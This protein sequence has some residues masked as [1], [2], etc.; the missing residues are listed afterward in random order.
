MPSSPS[1]T[2]SLGSVLVIGGC[3]FLGH[4]IVR[5]LLT[6]YSCTVSVIDLSVTR[7]RHANASYHSGDITSLETMT[8]LFSLIRP[9]VIIHT[10]SPTVTNHSSP[11]LYE[12]VNV[13][14]TRTLL[15]AAA[16]LPPGTV[17]AFIY[18]S[19]ASVV[20]D[21]ISPLCNATEDFPVLRAPAQ[22]DA[23]NETKGIAEGLVLAANRTHGM[24]T[25]A[26]RPSGIF[27]EG[28]VQ[29]VPGIYGAYTRGQTGFQ[30]GDNTNLS[31]FTYVG[32][33]V[34]AHILAVI[35]LLNTHALSPTIPL[36]HERV[37]GE[38]FFITNGSPT[39]FWD[40]ARAI[41]A[42][43]GDKREPQTGVWVIPKGPG[44]VIASIIEW[45]FWIVFLGK[46]T[47][48]LT[49]RVVN[50]SAMTR[51]YSIDKARKRLGYEPVVGLEQGLKRSVK[52]LIE[53]G[54]EGPQEGGNGV[55]EK[56]EKVQ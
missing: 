2:K 23:Y 7:N 33:V 27:G 34:H 53:N 14:G 8:A 9:S 55:L 18:T 25:L 45:I 17:K 29:A 51:Y 24:L 21:T 43:G 3:G 36:D 54:N 20:H 42:L 26:I 46:R 15:S 16:S 56:V 1:D 49:R 4:H 11:A 31:D 22:K 19:S 13:V 10:A 50:Y 35:A 6:S 28:D 44:L 5:T 37:D 47:P 30:L 32:N 48:N 52:W 38:A 12:K 40:F 41:W 39:P